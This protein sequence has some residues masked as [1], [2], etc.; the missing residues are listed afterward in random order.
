MV[1]ERGNSKHGPVR[2]E[3]LAEEVEDL[4][5]AR[6]DTR[7][8]EWRSPEPPGEDIPALAV[9]P[10]GA[11]LRG[12]APPGMTSADVEERSELARWLGRAVFPADRDE[13]MDHLR[14]Y[15]APD[16]VVDEVG[17]APA[18]VQFASLGQLWRAL[19]DGAHVESRRC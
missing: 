7:A 19:H 1:M 4:V 13:V 12:S 16:H 17:R 15:H 11:G 8:H 3:M 6:R 10:D 18:G 2:D 5:R 14:H 9:R